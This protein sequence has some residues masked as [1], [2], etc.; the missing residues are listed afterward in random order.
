MPKPL[1]F[2][3]AAAVVLV[4]GLSTQTTVAAWRAEGQIDA[5]QVRTGSL[6]LLAGNG[7]SAAK[8][9][10][11]AELNS[12]NLLPGSFV[13]APLTISNAGTTPLVYGLAGI[14]TGTASGS[15]KDQALVGAGTISIYAAVPPASCTGTQQISGQLLYSG[16]LN[17]SA[18]FASPRE[19]SAAGTPSASEALCVRLSLPAGTSQA[20]AGGRMAPTLS[21]TGQ[22]K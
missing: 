10:V 6:S 22:Q 11:F 14:T 1:K 21:F 2:A 8:D 12:Q 13:Q 16:P 5:G 15:A 9:Y 19:L 20:A 4:L 17:A 7:S 18:A 3:A